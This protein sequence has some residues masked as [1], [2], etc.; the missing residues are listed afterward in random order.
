[1]AL[2]GARGNAT[3]LSTGGLLA[4]T[5]YTAL[6]G[7]SPSGFTSTSPALTTGASGGRALCLLARCVGDATKEPEQIHIALGRSPD[8]MGVQW[9]TDA[10]AASA[11]KLCTARGS[12][13]YGRSAD[14]LDQSVAAECTPFSITGGSQLMQ[15]NYNATM[16]GLQPSTTYY[17]QI[18]SHAAPSAT[19]DARL[20]AC[21]RERR[22][23]E[24][25]S[26]RGARVRANSAWKAPPPPFRSFA[27]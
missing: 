10:G 20:R 3:H 16:A 4:D 25:W 1:M 26:E 22:E 23:A 11:D 13:A 6:V 14:Q 2:Y 15:S 18:T 7:V 8:Q 17:Y 5:S 24:P 19:L 9:A 21:D 12:V 27:R